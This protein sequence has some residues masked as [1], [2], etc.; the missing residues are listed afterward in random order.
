MRTAQARCFFPPI[1]YARVLAALLATVGL[2]ACTLQRDYVAPDLAAPAA[3]S[4]ASTS[5]DETAPALD[6]AWWRALGDP[7]IDAL[8]EAAF[9]DSPTLAHAVAR[10]D[11]AQAV[12]G[13]QSAATL[14]ALSA[15]AAITRAKSQNTMPLVASPTLLS[16]SLQAGPAFSW[17]IDL[18]G[19]V[20][21]TVDAAQRRLDAR[22]ADAGAAR[23]A[24]AAD[25]AS[26][27]TALRACDSARGVLAADIASRETTLPLTRLRLQA[28]FAPAVEE[29]RARSGIAAVRNS[30]AAQDEQ[31]ARSLNALVALSGMDAAGVA[32]LVRAPAGPAGAAGAFV[33]RAP[34]AAPQ[35]PATVLARHPSVIAAEREAAA[36]W[37]DMGAA[38]AQRLPRLDLAAALTGQWI[39]AAGSTLNFAAWS[40]GA[41]LGGTLFD[42]GAGSANLRAAEAR[43]R[44]AEASLRGTLRRT[45]QEVENALAA[46]ESARRRALSS[47][48]NVAAART[49][50]AASEA[51]WKA[52]AVSL[53]ELEESRR[54]FSAAQDAQISAR[55]DQ[56]QSWIALVK[57][58]G[59]AITLNA[60]VTQH[61]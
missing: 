49:T 31:C 32:L 34:D 9:A 24:L 55:R 17:E 20:R 18:F 53:F 3:W 41:S 29:A 50:L 46:Q 35:L 8:V 6:P 28:G 11:E 15:S 39:R 38:R 60:E 19:R 52:G 43:Y 2:G 14:P 57:A 58:T 45:V 5:G 48:D 22:S 16:N 10:M 7:A 47:A 13:V 51:Q 12:L 36:A 37:E 42:G 61:E 4:V 56:V 23:L 30:L 21:H 27:V 54:Q 1:R 44:Q 25:V 33:P 59:A 40:L 26:T